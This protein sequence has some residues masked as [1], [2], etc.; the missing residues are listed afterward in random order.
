MSLS[1]VWMNEW[2]EGERENDGIKY[3]IFVLFSRNNGKSI[4]RCL[5]IGFCCV[6][7][8][9]VVFIS[10]FL[11]AFVVH[12][13]GIMPKVNTKALNM[14]TAHARTHCASNGIYIENEK[15]FVRRH[16]KAVATKSQAVQQQCADLLN[17]TTEKQETFP[18]LIWEAAWLG[19]ACAM[20]DAIPNNS[21]ATAAT[22]AAQR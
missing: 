11:F 15:Q 7:F 3:L 6:R 20:L 4:E 2:S 16:R 17:G 22:A 10:S 14:P 5:S 19:L 8:L 1:S 21:V 12:K 18:E 13:M 9:R